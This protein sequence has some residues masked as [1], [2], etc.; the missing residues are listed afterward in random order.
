MALTVN[1]LK[2]DIRFHLL[3]QLLFVFAAVS[4]L[5]IGI[6]APLLFSEALWADDLMVVPKALQGEGLSLPSLPLLFPALNLLIEYAGSAANSRILIILIMA[7][8]GCGWYLVIRGW[9]D[10][11]LPATL[12]LLCAYAAP[13]LITQAMFVNGSHPA[14][15]M[16][17]FAWA[18]VLVRYGTETEHS[19]I[20]WLAWCLSIVLLLGM[21]TT[22]VLLWVV[23]LS[24]LP[25]A[26]T[27]LIVKKRTNA[28]IIFLCSTLPVLFLVTRRLIDSS[29]RYHYESSGWINFDLEAMFTRCTSLITKVFDSHIQTV[30]TLNSAVAFFCF[31]FFAVIYLRRTKSTKLEHRGGSWIPMVLMAAAACAIAPALTVSTAPERYLFAP[32]FL[33]VLAIGSAAWRW[34]TF[35]GG[36]EL[37]LTVT[38]TLIVS[39]ANVSKTLINDRYGEVFMLQSQVIDKLRPY[40]DSIPANGQILLLLEKM[41]NGFS[42]GFNHWSTYFLRYA[43]GRW[44]LIGL[45]GKQMWLKESPFVDKY[46]DHGDEYW[47]KTSDGPLQRKK[48]MGLEYSRPTLG[49]RLQNNGEFVHLDYLI[50]NTDRRL[51]YFSFGD[52]PSIDVSTP[53][54]AC[55][56]LTGSDMAFFSVPFPYSKSEMGQRKKESRTMVFAQNS[57]SL[58]VRE[59]IKGFHLKMRLLADTN[60]YNGGG[61]SSTMPPMPFLWRPFFIQQFQVNRYGVGGTL[62]Q[63]VEAS[64]RLDVE[65]RSEIGCFAEFTVNGNRWYE[66]GPINL[67]KEI[68][69]GKGYLDRYW[70][71]QIEVSSLAIQT[72]SGEWSNVFWSQLPNIY[73]RLE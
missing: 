65:I 66:W 40:A 2:M 23:S 11:F 36:R 64:G 58:D 24:L 26:I 44:D 54:A 50:F 45:V 47:V 22:S 5:L 63:T 13:A 38:L 52:A 4:L 60:I 28:L 72:A 51:E 53:D 42:S 32:V 20:C 68:L 3:W 62:L 56:D 15:A 43:T 12:I 73:S 17:Y 14:I 37:F 41:P 27:Q 19:G 35:T 46:A 30:I 31:L 1:N 18:M 49:Y 9:V 55:N 8:G 69:F 33:A 70:N 6:R 16:T 34:L 7:V 10:R 39:Y 48:M 29:S 67:G 71:G 57:I 25:Y 21:V 59:E 61:P